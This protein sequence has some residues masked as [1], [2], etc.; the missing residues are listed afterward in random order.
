MENYLKATDFLEI[1]H[2]STIHFCKDINPS[3]DKK[4][5]AI[6]LYYKVRD[7][8]LYDPFHLHLTS[9]ALKSSSIFQKKRAWC[10]EKAIVLATCARY[11][12]IPSRLGYAI[13]IN[14][15]GTEKLTRYLRRDEIVFHG[16]I[17]LFIE[18]KWVKCTPAFDKRVCKISGVTP[19]DWDGKTDSLFQAFEKDQQFMEYLHDYETFDDVPVGLM[20]KEMKHYYPHLFENIIDTKEF[21]FIPES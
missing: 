20:N 2:S 19:L 15:I 8:F 17:E 11:F 3:Q 9:E 5:L 1:H 21:S 6:E 7:H 18:N 10:V 4:E 14:H 12:G 16:Y 13:V